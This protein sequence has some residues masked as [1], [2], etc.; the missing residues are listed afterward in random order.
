M[1]IKVKTICLDIDNTIC[2]TIGS[3]YKKQNQF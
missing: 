2:K 3:N 1:T